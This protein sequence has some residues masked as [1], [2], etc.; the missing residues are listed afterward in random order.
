MEDKLIEL[1]YKNN[2][3]LIEYILDKIQE[4]GYINNNQEEIN[5]PQAIQDDSD[6]IL[7]DLDIELAIQQDKTWIK[8]IS[9]DILLIINQDK[10]WEVTS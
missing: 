4:E 5:I 1:L 3:L 6:W 10:N 8:A 2:Q 9:E 7:D